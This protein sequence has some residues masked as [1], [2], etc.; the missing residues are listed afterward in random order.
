MGLFN[1]RFSDR[2]ADVIKHFSNDPEPSFW[3]KWFGGLV[4]PVLLV[5]Y[6][7]RCC[8]LREAVLRGRGNV[9]T[10]YGAEAVALGLA[11]IFGA[12][13]LHFHYFWTT[14]PRLAYFSELGKIIAG[15]GFVVSFC[16]ALWRIALNM[17]C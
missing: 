2:N 12:L 6:G 16:Y 3:G 4:V 13:F 17:F 14:S 9:M 1:R 8:V 7:G 5:Y 11:W 10:V 15:A